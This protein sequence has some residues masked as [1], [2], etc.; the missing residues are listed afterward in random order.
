MKHALPAIGLVF[1]EVRPIA[2]ADVVHCQQL[3]DVILGCGIGTPFS[4]DDHLYRF[5]NFDANVF[6]NPGI[7]DVG[8]ADAE[9]DATNRANVRG[10]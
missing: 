8:S 7:E 9:G 1:H 5:G 10:V 3:E 4:A 6:R 2:A